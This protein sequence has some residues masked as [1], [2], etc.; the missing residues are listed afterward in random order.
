MQGCDGSPAMDTVSVDLPRGWHA[1]LKGC[2]EFKTEATAT[3]QT[4]YLGGVHII[5]HYLSLIP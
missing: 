2:F 1:H 5:N 4:Y 3:M